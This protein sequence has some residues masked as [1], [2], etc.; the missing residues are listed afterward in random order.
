M[1]IVLKSPPDSHPATPLQVH[2]PAVIG[3]C[4]KKEVLGIGAFRVV[5][6]VENEH[7]RRNAAVVN[8]PRNPMS[9]QMGSLESF[10]DSTIPHVV[11]AASPAP[12]I[13]RL[14]DLLPEAE[15]Q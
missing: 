13:T 11:F 5:A 3:E 7:S 6:L 12:T 4:T 2:V 8:I 9:E 15:F 10:A 1:G 14:F